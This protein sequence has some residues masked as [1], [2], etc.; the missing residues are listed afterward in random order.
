VNTADGTSVKVTGNFVDNQWKR[1]SVQL[2]ALAPGV[3]KV[4][5]ITQFSSGGIPLKDPRQI[6]Y[7]AA[8][9]GS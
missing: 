3:Y 8:L 4:R 9:T 7:E 1:L 6:D 5:V 2:P